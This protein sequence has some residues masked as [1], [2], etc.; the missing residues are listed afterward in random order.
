[1]PRYERILPLVGILLMGLALILV[2][3]RIHALTIDV[4]LPQGSTAS[5]SIAWLVMFFLLIVAAIGAESIQREAEHGEVDQAGGGR[6]RLHLDAWIMPVLIILTAF[7][8]LRLNSLLVR[9]LGLAVVG[10]LLLVA[11]VAPHYR[12]DERALQRVLGRQ[13]LVVL[14]FFVGFFL[15]GAIYA[16]KLRSLFSATAIVVLTF[17]LAWVLLRWER[18]KTGASG[19]ALLL[20]AAVVGLGVGEVT[21]P[22]NYWVIEGLIGG[23]FLLVAFYVLVNIVRHHVRDSLSLRMVWE[24]ILVGLLCVAAIALYAFRLRLF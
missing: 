18:P 11:L 7:L 8:F 6:Q 15:Y 22:L 4:P 16:L 20:Y 9:S 19:Q 12:D 1:M 23:T 5:V 3:E 10:L 13:A 17:L 2:V 24:Y 21:W 14:V